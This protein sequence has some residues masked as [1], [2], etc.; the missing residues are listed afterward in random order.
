MHQNKINK[1]KEKNKQ[2]RELSESTESMKKI[3]MNRKIDDFIKET[4]MKK[5]PGKET[6]ISVDKSS[7]IDTAIQ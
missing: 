6:D 2:L 3:I 5:E 1:I 4:D 7:S